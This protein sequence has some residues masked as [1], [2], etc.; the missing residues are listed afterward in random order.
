MR[1]TGIRLSRT[2]IPTF[3]IGIYWDILS[4]GGSIA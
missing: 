2:C 4:F 3:Y 1:P